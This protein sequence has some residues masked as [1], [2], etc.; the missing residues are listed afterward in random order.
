MASINEQLDSGAA[1]CSITHTHAI[2]NPVM[3]DDVSAAHL[4]NCD[5]CGSGVRL[6]AYFVPLTADQD[7]DGSKALK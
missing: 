7:Q 1:L 5:L 4:L 3:V 2:P 6:K